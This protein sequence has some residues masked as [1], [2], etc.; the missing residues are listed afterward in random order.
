MKKIQIGARVTVEDAE[1]INLLEIN[2]AKTPSDKLRAII[3]EARLQRE[4]S[5]DFS[6]SYLIIQE[7]ITPLVERIKN[8]EFE[9]N[10]HSEVLARILEWFPEFY[11]YC[12]SALPEN[13][14]SEKVLCVYEKGIVERIARLFE[15]LLQQELSTRE[16]SYNQDMIRDHVV[17]L[18]RIINIINVSTK[19]KEE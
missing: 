14:E 5:Q 12:L 8:A 13:I 16:N 9:S 4:Y 1:F 6:G 3:K 7:Q 2:G 19:E 18:G 15:A 17:S 11:A 10:T